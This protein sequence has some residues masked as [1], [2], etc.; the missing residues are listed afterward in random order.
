LRLTS[1]GTYPG[2]IEKKSKRVGSAR[3]WE[4]K[5]RD[6]LLTDK[7]KINARLGKKPKS[8]EGEKNAPKTKK[9]RQ[10]WLPGGEGQECCV[11]KTGRVTG[12]K[13]KKKLKR[14][15][16]TRPKGAKKRE[17]KGNDGDRRFSGR[18]TERNASRT[19]REEEKGTK[20]ERSGERR[21]KWETDSGA[22]EEKGL[23][24]DQGPGR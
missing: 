16:K 22:R 6:H 9:K 15:G 13:K 14:A 8:L 24:P 20:K 10:K 21:K 17:G 19:V 11:E 1:R 18:G 12:G 3:G 23:M 4:K 7:K 2:L 5:A